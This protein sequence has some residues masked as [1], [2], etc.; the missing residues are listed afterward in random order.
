MT[1]AERDARIRD[2]VS[3]INY[4]SGIKQK[5]EDCKTEIG[6]QDKTVGESVLDPINKP[7]DLSG[8]DLDWQGKNYEKANSQMSVIATAVSSYRGD[9]AVL[10]S[11][12]QAAI[13]KLDDEIS[14]L[15]SQL[16]A[17]TS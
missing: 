6:K 13:G 5:L 10:Q 9:V 1:D 15:Q 17:L 3:K 16:S 7:Y 8:G 12:I 14:S 4:F 2:L 11:N